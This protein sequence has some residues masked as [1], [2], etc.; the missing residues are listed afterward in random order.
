MIQKEAEKAMESNNPFLSALK[1]ADFSIQSLQVQGNGRDLFY[2]TDPITNTEKA[3]QYFVKIP[4]GL[5]LEGSVVEPD[6]MLRALNCTNE[7]QIVQDSE[8]LVGDKMGINVVI[9]NDHFKCKVHNGSSNATI[10]NMSYKARH[11]LEGKDSPELRLKYQ[12]DAAEILTPVIREQSNYGIRIIEDCIATG[13]SIIGVLKMLSTISKVPVEG[14]KTIRIDVAVATAQ[15]LLILEK[16]AQQ[17]N[18]KIDINV[19]SLAYGLSKGVDVEGTTAKAHSN[20]LVYPEFMKKKFPLLGHY[21]FVVGDMGELFKSLSKDYDEVFGPN[22]SRVNDL[23]GDRNVD[24]DVRIIDYSRLDL[25]K[26]IT[27][28]LANG[29]YFTRALKHYLYPDTYSQEVIIRASRSVTEDA[30]FGVR[31]GGIGKNDKIPNEIL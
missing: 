1:N 5:H 12:Q 27:I 16:F 22:A 3:A 23:H 30:G 11:H 10:I 19:T 7:T 14:N 21:E 8:K 4:E 17:N 18:L 29:G 9:A 24:E 25:R 6:V 31:L 26:P 13:D 20:Y 2:L 28:Y 15:G